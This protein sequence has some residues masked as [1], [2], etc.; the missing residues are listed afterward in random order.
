MRK[1]IVVSF[2]IALILPALAVGK[3]NTEAHFQYGKLEVPGFAG[4]GAEYTSIFTIQHFGTWR[5]GSV[6]GFVD[7]SHSSR[8]NG[9]NDSDVYGELYPI[10]SLSKITGRNIGVG[11]IKDIGIVT[12]I[13]IG[14]DANVRK[15]LPGI[16]LHFDVPDF[17]FVTLKLTRYID[18]NKGLSSGGAPKEDDGFDV[19]LSWRY[20]FK[21]KSAQFSIEGHAEYL[22]GRYNELGN[23][24]S[25]SLLA[26]PQLRWYLADNVAIG[27]EYQIWINKLG[28]KHTNEYRPQALAV[29]KF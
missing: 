17:S 22:T 12:G 23:W 13:N 1:M 11:P 28:D 6:F 5:Y 29:Y 26:Q 27:I 10:F 24:V 21:I 25:P 15:Y 7:V 4:G 2:L 19:D 20:P 18:G 3:S 8:N 9:F 16:S 14:T